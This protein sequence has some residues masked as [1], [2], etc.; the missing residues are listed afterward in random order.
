MDLTTIRSNG[1]VP[2]TVSRRADASFLGLLND[3]EASGYNIAGNQSGGF[4][5]RNI[6]GTNT[7]SQH[8][9][10]R[11]IDINWDQNARGTAG[12]IDP[13]LARALAS[14]YGLKWGGDWK[15][16]DPMHFE[17]ASAGAPSP[18]PAGHP[19]AS[20]PQAQQRETMPSPQDQTPPMG[21]LDT[22]AG[23]M[24]SP[25]VQGGLGLLLAASQGGNMAAGLQGGLQTGGAMARNDLD[26]MKARR[27]MQRQQIMDEFWK[28]I[29]TN[30]ALSSL[31]P[32]I[33][34]V[35]KG[36]PPDQGGTMIGNYV[37]RRKDVDQMGEI[38]RQNAQ[39][40]IEKSDAL[41]KQNQE[42]MFK[43]LEGIRNMG[44]P[45][46]SRIPRVQSEADLEA[47]PPGAVFIAPDG[48]QRRK[49]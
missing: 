42:R 15:N 22:L 17:V 34:E 4:N 28:G 24:Q 3:L 39:I 8:S 29:G 48:S 32:E 46:Q 16:P 41:A 9:F 35:A 26:V 27:E 30:K 31:P 19:V 6:A 33:L 43:T 40:E 36:L 10:G 1:G 37:G 25:L 18:A 7:P 2:F 14:K 47:L 20:Y 12:N 44:K 5:P 38:A 23:R 13:N 11:A 49:P 21:I 45:T